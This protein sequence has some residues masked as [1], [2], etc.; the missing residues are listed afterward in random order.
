M[1][2]PPLVQCL[3]CF[4]GEQ[5]SL[6]LQTV[7]GSNDRR[8]RRERDGGASSRN[9]EHGGVLTRR[10]IRTSRE[11]SGTATLPMQN[12]DWRPCWHGLP[13]DAEAVKA[14]LDEYL[15]GADRSTAGDARL[16][17]RRLTS[18][19]S[20]GW[21]TYRD[22]YGCAG[23]D[24]AIEL[25]WSWGPPTTGEPTDSVSHA[26]HCDSVRQCDSGPAVHDE[27]AINPRS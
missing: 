19:R 9:V 26:N 7:T 10:D 5:T 20:G 23:P 18:A 2:I 14:T 21:Q 6:D 13:E 16:R 22:A 25:S 24:H 15:K 1:I 3:A 27:L 8:T 17:L 12:L 4:D 11:T